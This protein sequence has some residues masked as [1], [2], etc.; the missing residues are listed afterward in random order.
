MISTNQV[1]FWQKIRGKI[2]G[3]I[4]GIYKVIE[5]IKK[6]LLAI[7][8]HKVKQIIAEHVITQFKL[9]PNHFLRLL[10]D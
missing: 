5:V 3:K 9:I 4:L 1:L 2:P 7:M 8:K 10:K 6:F